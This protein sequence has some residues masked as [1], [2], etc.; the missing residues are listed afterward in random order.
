MKKPS[1]IR[2]ASCYIILIIASLFFVFPLYYM[3]CAASG[4]NLD[5]HNGLLIPGT[6]LFENIAYILTDSPF[7]DSF[8]F[9]LKYTLIQTVITL[10]IC[11]MAGYAFEMFHDRIKDHVFQAFLF[12]LMIPFTGTLIPLYKMYARMGLI[13][14]TAGLILPFLASPLIVMIFR[15][16]TRTFPKELIEAARLDGLREFG[17]FFRIYLPNMKGTVSCGIIIAFLNAWN[18]YQWP[19]VVI[20]ERVKIPMTMYLTLMGKGDRMTLVLLSMIPTMI[21]FFIFQKFF[22]EGLSGALD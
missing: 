8:L 20:T 2:M 11:A 16:N 12:A 21:V 18:S 7:M 14:T 13:N 10:L 1:A 15:Q 4:G 6:H 9:S 3:L 17:I 5:F 19:R 22:V